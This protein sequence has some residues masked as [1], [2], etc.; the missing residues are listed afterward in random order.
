MRESIAVSSDGE[1]ASSPIGSA[2]L[3]CCTDETNS[4]VFIVR[5]SLRRSVMIMSKLVGSARTRASAA[6]GVETRSIVGGLVSPLS[7]YSSS[8]SSVSSPS[9]S[10]VYES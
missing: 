2:A 9:C 3:T 5:P 8:T 6:S 7:A 4:L 1:S 10:K